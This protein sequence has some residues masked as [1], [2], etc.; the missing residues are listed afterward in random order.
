MD[1]P[2]PKEMLNR[3]PT[4]SNAKW[5]KF[6]EEFSFQKFVGCQIKFLSD[7]KIHSFS[8]FGI[9]EDTYFDCPNGAFYFK[10]IE[11]I[12]IPK[13][14]NNLADFVKILDTI[15]VF[16]YYIDENGFTICGYQ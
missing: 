9:V 10:E 3:Y 11:W 15:G 7:E 1:K 12:F 4:M 6:A 8:D 2:I 13:K 5:V 14:E 16:P